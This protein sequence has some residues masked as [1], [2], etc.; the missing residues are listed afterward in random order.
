MRSAPTTALVVGGLLLGC[1]SGVSWGNP[2]SCSITATPTPE[3]SLADCVRIGVGANL[4]LIRRALER[5]ANRFDLDI[6]RRVT[7]PAVTAQVT[8][9]RDASRVRT[10]QQG[11]AVT[12][13]HGTKVNLRNETREI[14]DRPGRDERTQVFSLTQPLMKNFGRAV[15][16]YELD[17]A[18]YD[19]RAGVEKFR[20]DLDAF[21]FDLLALCLDLSFARRNL[22]IQ[23]AACERARRQFEDTRHDIDLGAIAEREIYLVEENLVGFEI[24]RQNAAQEIALLDLRLRQ[25][26]DLDPC[27][28]A[29]LRVADALFEDFGEPVPPPASFAEILAVARRESPDLAVERLLLGR[30]LTTLERARLQANP[31]L[32]LTADLRWRDG[33]SSRANAWTVGIQYELP[34]SRAAEQATVEKAR[35]GTRIREVA[36]QDADARLAWRLRNVLQ[37]IDHLTR[38]GVEKRRAVGLAQ[39]K[40]EAEQEKYRNG[41]STLADL[42][43]FQREL[44]VAQIDEIANQVTLRKEVLRRGLLEGTLHRRFG[45][46]I[47]R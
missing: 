10:W 41:F 38:V 9:G 37:Q 45:I 40:L 30:S 43:R 19:Y 24:K 44:E 34:W 29:P 32:D 20:A 27:Q 3:L 42:V 33:G 46:E 5:D 47:D 6:A 4:T 28:D 31:R 7:I 23:E 1:L 2:A 17:I 25:F 26:L 8:E 36:L 39:K 11:F 12:G 35:F 18:R 22:A 21:V 16:G 15:T 14:T 13:A